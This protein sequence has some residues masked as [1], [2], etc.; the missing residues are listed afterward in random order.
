MSSLRE[1]HPARVPENEQR[2]HARAAPR[3]AS[4]ALCAVRVRAPRL[5]RAAQPRPTA[6]VCGPSHPPTATPPRRETCQRSRRLGTAPGGATCPRPLVEIARAVAHTSQLEQ[7]HD[8]LE[9]RLGELDLL[10]AEEQVLAD[11]LLAAAR[12][13]LAKRRPARA[14]A[15]DASGAAAA[16]KQGEGS[17]GTRAGAANARVRELV[18]LG[19][20]RR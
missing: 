12:V 17:E 14:G 3:G 18:D 9:R 11:L 4:L 15:S 13:V 19:D 20:L 6:G 8:R 2:D 7:R 1:A 5:T 10:L 16:A